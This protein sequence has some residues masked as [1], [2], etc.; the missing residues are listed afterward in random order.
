MVPSLYFLSKAAWP[1]HI[2]RRVIPRQT[3]RRVNRC[4]ATVAS[5]GR[6]RTFKFVPYGEQFQGDAT[7]VCVDGLVKGVD[8]QLTH[9]TGESG[10]LELPVFIPVHVNTPPLTR[11]PPVAG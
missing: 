2:N 5:S 8:L 11:A 10:R 6:R 9:W 4:S 7:T 3:S 1:K